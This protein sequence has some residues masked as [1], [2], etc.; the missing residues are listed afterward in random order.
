MIRKQYNW[1][2]VNDVFKRRL[3]TQA[4]SCENTTHYYST[5][6]LHINLVSPG[7]HAL[8]DVAPHRNP[9]ISWKQKDLN[10]SDDIHTLSVFQGPVSDAKNRGEMLC[11]AL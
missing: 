10:S 11:P 2:P 8:V 6:N 9:T 7:A 3:K 5:N 4:L 1:S